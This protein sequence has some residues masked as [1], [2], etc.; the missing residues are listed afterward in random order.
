[1]LKTIK[2]TI[3]KKK[4]YNTYTKQQLYKQLNNY[5]TKQLSNNYTKQL[6]LG[7]I[8]SSKPERAIIFFLKTDCS[9]FEVNNA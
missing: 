4:Q 3:I 6:Y 5:T 1:V 8:I 2:T 9:N 7:E